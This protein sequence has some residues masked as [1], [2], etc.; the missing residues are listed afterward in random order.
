VDVKKIVTKR[1]NSLLGDLF[2]HSQTNT[3]NIYSLFPGGR[4]RISSGNS[5]S[6]MD[7]ILGTGD[8][9][10]YP[11]LPAGLAGGRLVPD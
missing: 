11:F 7:C 6:E 9:N 2:T 10:A 1:V 5:C 4:V 3:Q 8:D